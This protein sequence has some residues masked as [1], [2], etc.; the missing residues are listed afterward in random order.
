MSSFSWS[1]FLDLADQLQSGGD[2]ARFRTAVSRAYYAAFQ[3]AKAYV[4]RTYGLRGKG[5]IHDQTWN[6]LAGSMQPDEHLIGQWGGD[7]KRKRCRA[8]YDLSPPVTSTIA[9]QAIAE[10]RKVRDKLSKL[11]RGE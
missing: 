9:M 6:T 11:N 2:E 3:A 5:N 1:Q 7:L 10:A 4:A 8:D